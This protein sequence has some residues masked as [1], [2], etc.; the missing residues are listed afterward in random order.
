MTDNNNNNPPKGV[1]STGE[2]TFRDISQFSKKISPNETVSLETNYALQARLGNFFKN[3]PA[4]VLEFSKKFSGETAVDNKTPSPLGGPINYNQT[5]IVNRQGSGF[6][7]DEFDFWNLDSNLYK[8]KGKPKVIATP[9]NIPSF[10]QTTPNVVTKKVRKIPPTRV[11]RFT[12]S[13]NED[14]KNTMY[15]SCGCIL[16]L[17]IIGILIFTLLQSSKTT[18]M[19]MPMT[20]LGP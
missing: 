5:N 14:N 16:M 20:N 6:F 3:N 17:I 12:G 19:S 11:E 7:S 8:G 4:Q 13:K 18:P 10:T 15:L 9:A 2:Q 1:F